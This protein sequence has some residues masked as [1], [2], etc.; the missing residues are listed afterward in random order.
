LEKC[1]TS[2]DPAPLKLPPE[3]ARI[4]EAIPASTAIQ[5][6]AF[7]SRLIL[8]FPSVTERIARFVSDHSQ[9]GKREMSG[10]LEILTNVDA[11]ATGVSRNEIIR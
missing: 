11:G 4:V 10:F 3:N 5:I 1:I 6:N 7:W 2:E 8:P 9:P